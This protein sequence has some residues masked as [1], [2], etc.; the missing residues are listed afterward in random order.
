[1]GH[2]LVDM[3]ASAMTGCDFSR[4]ALVA[5][6][7]NTATLLATDYLNHFN[8]ITMLI[9]LVGDM[10][11]MVEELT[12]WQPASYEEHFERSTFKGKALAIA[13]Y[14]AALPAVRQK[15]VEVVDEMNT[16]ILSTIARLKKADPEDYHRIAANGDRPAARNPG[17]AARRGAAARRCRD[18]ECSSRRHRYARP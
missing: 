3:H 18:R 2:A 14:Q 4:E 12:V 7:I 17:R 6:N 11:D 16:A 1:M 8:E 15:F 9:G 13:A 5:A 10:P